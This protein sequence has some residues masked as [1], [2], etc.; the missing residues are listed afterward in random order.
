MNRSEFIGRFRR[1]LAE[2][3]TGD[4]DDIIAEYEQHFERRMADGRSE[5]EVAALLGAPEELA[6]QFAPD[7]EPKPH[8][9]SVFAT[10][11]GLGVADVTF[12]LGAVPLAGGWLAVMGSV[13]LA[14]LLGGLALIFRLHRSVAF[15]SVPEMPFIS[16]LLLGLATL[17]LG[18]LTSVGAWYCAR[19]FAQMLRAYGRWRRNTWA[20]AK[21]EPTLPP[22]AVYPHLT[23]KTRR[24]ARRVA[25]PSLAAFVVTFAAGYIVSAFLAGDVEFWHVWQWFV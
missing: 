19:L 11:L 25:L 15:F 10:A 23:A 2:Q 1:V 5:E 3:R 7:K 20:A 24:A 4:S 9:G 13:S 22:L 17:S 16:C 18:V 12:A 14:F 21:G 8:R 6:R